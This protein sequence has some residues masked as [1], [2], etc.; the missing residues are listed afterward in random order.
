MPGR[1]I[2]RNIVSQIIQDFL[3]GIKRR[4]AIEGLDLLP[5]VSTL[6]ENISFVEGEDFGSFKLS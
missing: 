6:S 4:G 3:A 5:S 1:E 2:I